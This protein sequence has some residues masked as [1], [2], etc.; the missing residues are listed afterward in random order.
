[1][2]KLK[3]V[4]LSVSGASGVVYGLRLAQ[5]LLQLPARVSLV[6][7]QNARVIIE[8]E[9]GIA[10][11]LSPEDSKDFLLE[12]LFFNV[13]AENLQIFD[14]KNWNAPLASGSGAP[15]IYA[16]CPASMATIA[17][18]ANGSA[19]NLITRAADVILKL[20]RP[21]LLMPREMPFSTLHLK[22]LLRLSQMGAAIFP[23]SPAFYHNPQNIGDLVD[24]VVSRMLDFLNLAPENLPR[25]G[26]HIENDDSPR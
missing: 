12:N 18:I 13:P 24:F 4:G 8:S 17:D 11:P 5:C 21:F 1:M 25:W 10:L 23:A 7:S 22:N 3:H 14:E 6:F 2:E 16:I 15:D 19:H 26:E 9:C 20:R